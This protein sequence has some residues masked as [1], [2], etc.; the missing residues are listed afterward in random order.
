MRPCSL[1]QPCSLGAFEPGFPPWPE[2]SEY[3]AAFEPSRRGLQI[4]FQLYI[5]SWRVVFSSFCYLSLS[6]SAYV[7]SVSL[8]SHL[9]LIFL[10][11][12]AYLIPSIICE[13]SFYLFF[14]LSFLICTYRY[15][16]MFCFASRHLLS[17][18]RPLS[19]DVSISLPHSLSFGRS[20]FSLALCGV[21]G[22]E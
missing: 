13:F 11:S 19:V 22:T 5:I 9:C 20:V 18:S 6:L 21:L 12:H 8:P 1:Q 17:F 16:Y 14:P 7:M 4:R 2:A 15:I 3:K 10:P